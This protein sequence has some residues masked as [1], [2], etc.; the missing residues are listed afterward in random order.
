[1]NEKIL[2]IFT[3]ALNAYLDLDPESRQR[4]ANLNTQVITIEL[5]PFHF[6]FQCKFEE[7]GIYLHQ[8]DLLPAETRITGTPLQLMSV[9]V[10]K[11]DRQRFFAEDVAMEGNAELGHEVIALFDELQIDWEE[12]LSHLIGDIPAHHT[13]RVVRGI[14]SWIKHAT[15]SFVANVDEYVHEEKTGCQ[16]A[17]PCKTFLKILIVCAWMSTE[18]RQK[19][20]N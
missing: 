15:D 5:L 10:M 2:S 6:I 8:H 20:H 17:K 14:K 19:W 9:A 12:Y 13:G 18:Q 11:N 4:L 1:M 16:L 7:N 3:K